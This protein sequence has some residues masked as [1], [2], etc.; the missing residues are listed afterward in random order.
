MSLFSFY[1]QV[2]SDLRVVEMHIADNRFKPTKFTTV[3][4]TLKHHTARCFIRNSLSDLSS[5]LQQ[6][7]HTGS[8]V[9]ILPGTHKLC[10][11]FGQTT[12]SL[13]SYL[14]S[15]IHRPPVLSAA[16]C[17][18]LLRNRLLT[19]KQGAD[20]EGEHTKFNHSGRREAGLK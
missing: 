18:P 20:G 13:P 19:L 10:S 6:C 9:Q 15:R 11:I 16:S 2:T 8:W 5:Q 4:P 17:S 14:I 1:R 12:D 7:R 3:I